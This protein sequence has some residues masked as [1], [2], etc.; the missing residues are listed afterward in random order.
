[1]SLLG[2]F[3]RFFWSDSLLP[4][5]LSVGTT[6]AHSAIRSVIM[7]LL[8]QPLS[9]LAM[10]ATLGFAAPAEAGWSDRLDEAVAEA[11]E[12]TDALA[13]M[14]EQAIILG[15]AVLY[16]NRHTIAGASLGCAAGAGL[17]ALSTAALAP[18]TGGATLAGAGYA[19]LF[20][21]GAGAVAGAQIGYPLDHV[22]EEE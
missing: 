4:D 10:L 20:G 9:L 2:V 18:A 8:R 1:M 6:L 14:A 19:A 15:G 12:T 11:R 5:K 3:D 7:L 22:F 21:C 13:A 16:Q 17:G